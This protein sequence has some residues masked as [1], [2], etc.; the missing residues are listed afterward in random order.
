MK[1]LPPPPIPIPPP[2]THTT[3]FIIS[4]ALTIRYIVFLYVIFFLFTRMTVPQGWAETCLFFHCWNSTTLKNI[5]HIALRLD[6]W[7]ISMVTS[8]LKCVSNS[9]Q[10]QQ[11][12]INFLRSCV[13]D[14]VEFFKLQDGY[15]NWP[16]LDTLGLIALSAT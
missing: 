14:H 11:K 1:E 9:R 12:N 4:I 8:I 16:W 10:T 6:D 2:H 13:Y 7:M 5:C 3:C 15:F